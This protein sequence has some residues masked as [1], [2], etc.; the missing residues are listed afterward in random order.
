MTAVK[1][2]L[3]SDRMSEL[4]GDNYSVLLVMSRFGI[5]LGFGDRTVEEVCARA[6]VDAPTLDRKSVV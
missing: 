1:K 5:S 2:Y 6:G 3:R 4:V